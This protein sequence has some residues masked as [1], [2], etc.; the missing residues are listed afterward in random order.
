MEVADV[1]ED[2]E[3]KGSVARA[4]FVDDEVL[5]GEVGELVVCDEVAGDGFPIV[6]AEELGWS[7]PQLPSVVGMLGVE[8]VFEIGVALAQEGVEMG[9]V[10]HGVEVEGLTGR[11]YDDLLRE[12]AIIWIV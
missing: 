10:G 3:H 8:S 11:E 1:V 6:G 7:V 5:V 12:V 9:F 2:V 4:Q